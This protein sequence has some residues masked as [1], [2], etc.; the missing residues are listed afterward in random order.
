MRGGAEAGGG[1]AQVTWERP[2]ALGWSRRSFNKTFWWNQVTGETQHEE[3]VDVFGFDDGAGYRFFI[4]PKT[5]QS[6]WDRPE[7]SAWSEVH[8][9]E[10]G[11]PYYYNN[12]TQ[13]VSWEKP[14]DSNIAWV[15]YHEELR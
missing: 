4:D 1:R 9:E 5:G 12:V 15:K 13:E 10:H 14:A 8:S 11:R 2:A 6:S 3:P 7:R